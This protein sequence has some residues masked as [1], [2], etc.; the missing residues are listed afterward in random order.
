MMRAVGAD[1]KD[2]KWE[3]EKKQAITKSWQCKGEGG[4]H[5]VMKTGRQKKETGQRANAQ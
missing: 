2:N 1:D 5:G 4:A 3:R